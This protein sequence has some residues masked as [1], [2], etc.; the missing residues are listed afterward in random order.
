MLVGDLGHVRG[1][2]E[3]LHDW[4]GC[5]GEGVGE[6]WRWDRTSAPEGRLGEGRGSDSQRG[7]L[8]V[9]ESVGMGR[10]LRGIRG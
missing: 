7:P 8:T 4:V 10:D 1:W 6:K 9:R 2:E 5:V 3:P